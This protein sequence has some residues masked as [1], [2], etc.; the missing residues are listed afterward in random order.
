MGLVFEVAAPPATA[1]RHRADVACFIGFVGRR[2]GRSLP[3]ALRAQLV[4]A[5]WTQGPW[6][7]SASQVES[8]LNLP[9][10]IDS[11]HLFDRL[12]AWDQRPVTAAG[13]VRCATALGA[14]VRSFFAHGGRRAVVI[15]VG[16]PWPV[17]EDAGRRLVLR[18][19]RL[20][21]MLPD[22]AN[23]TAPT[24]PFEPHNPA[25]WQGIQHLYGLR[26]TS[27]LLLP[28]M[29]DIC[30]VDTLPAPAA[31]QVALSPEGFVECSVEDVP[32]ADLGLSRLAAPRLNASGY[33]A[34]QLAISA[35]RGFLQRWQREIHLVAALPLPHD[36]AVRIVGTGRLHAQ[37]DM[38]GYL[39][40]IGA[41]QPEGSAQEPG[42]TA[43]SAFVQLAWPWLRCQDSDDLPQGLASPDG[44]LAG[45]IAGTALQ[46]G[47]FRS[48]AGDASL[49]PLRDVA[50]AEPVPAWGG[51]ETSPT[52]LLARRV[53]LIAQGPD[54]WAL[55]SDVTTSPQE[56]WR[57]GGASRLMG[58]L[59][60]AARR[61]G[62]GLAFEPSGPLLWARARSAI[63]DLLLSFWREGA[64]AGASAA[65]AFSVRCDRSTMT[66]ADLDNGRLI[67]VVS[68][69][70]AAAIERI[71]VVLNLGNPA[72]AAGAVRVAA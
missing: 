68:V 61:V 30:A 5:G 55:Q 23:Q 26:E 52:A 58:L 37:A 29:P 27:L 54:G 40:R 42:N 36:D 22:F 71:T 18:R 64:L 10:V 60:R 44:V 66:P 34:W 25:S 50:D 24:Q 56:A 11:W 45:L 49:A 20:R 8:L 3:A 15:R 48:A 12:Y 13:S 9:L 62:E 43:S 33:A 53:C 21:R 47:T 38:L 7:R 65:Q 70:P 2:A 31:P 6:G 63:E 28:D 46:R 41:L 69:R 51:S 17:V 35:A 32:V 4:E 57:F 39:R 14:A 19:W 72:D 16:D 67:V 1:G 59:L